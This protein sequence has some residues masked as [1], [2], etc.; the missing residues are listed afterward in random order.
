MK[1]LYLLGLNSE[2][3]EYSVVHSSSIANYSLRKSNYWLDKLLLIIILVSTASLSAQT[4]FK[5][6]LQNN[7]TET[8][9]WCNLQSPTILTL[10]SDEYGSVY[11]QVYKEGL[12]DVEGAADGIEAW[13]GISAVGSNPNPN[14]WAIWFPATYHGDSGNNDEYL[15]SIFTSYVGTYYMASRFRLNGGDFIYGGV[16]GTWNGIT[17]PSAALVITPNIMQCATNVSP[18]NG[19]LNVPVGYVNLSWNAPTSGPTPA[20]YDIYRVAEGQSY[21]LGTSTTTSFTM[22]VLTYYSLI[23]W[24]VV[25]R[26]ISGVPASSCTVN[27]FGTGANPLNPYCSNVVYSAGVHPITEVNFA[28]IDNSSTNEIVA[29]PS[30]QNFKDQYGFVSVGET[31]MLSIRGNTNGANVS[32]LKVFIDWNMDNDFNDDGESYD[33]GSIFNSDGINGEAAISYITVP[34]NALTGTTRMRIKKV[35]GTSTLSNP[36]TGGEYGQTEDYTLYVQGCETSIWYRDADGDGFGTVHSTLFSCSQPTGYVADN[37]DC[38]DNNANVNPNALEVLYNGI[39][40]NCDGSM[41]EGFM[42][43]TYIKPEFCGTILPQLDSKIFVRTLP[44]ASAYRFEVIAQSNGLVQYVETSNSYFRVTDMPFYAYGETYRISVQVRRFYTP[45]STN[46][47]LGYYGPPCLVSTPTPPISLMSNIR[48][49]GTTISVYGAL[50]AR[51]IP[52][53]TAYRFILKSHLDDPVGM[54]VTRDVPYVNLNM[55]SSYDYGTTYY[56]G[57][58]VKTMGIF[59]PYS[60]LCPVTTIS[61]Q[62]FGFGIAQCGKTYTNIYSSINAGSIPLATEYRFL[63]TRVFDGSQQIIDTYNTWIN[64][65]QFSFYSPSSEYSIAIAVRTS[66]EFST[67]GNPCSIYSPPASIA[68]GTTIVSADFKVV[69]SPN[70]FSDTF[71]LDITE[72]S[73]GNAEVR[74]FDMIG[75]LLE[76]RSVQSSDLSSQRLGN[77][78]PSG[79]YTVV[80][81]Q[82]D[83]VRT[84]K[85]IKR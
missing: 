82:G 63:I 11:A 32:N 54:V 9:D 80:V 31:Y 21:L 43:L 57:V 49:C 26:S 22:T 10:P 77:S 15:A 55:F 28:G 44:E 27:S 33:A 58:S 85:V 76:V 12:T 73:A 74:V 59:G 3:C 25:P 1:I 65:S 38:N 17:S 2:T 81:T 69:A 45:T 29:L 61:P 30:I 6:D 24:K 78:F 83:A 35:S 62:E 14:A 84:L 50:N 39:D 67:F 42:I 46:I 16:N 75:K 66:G 56:V 68:S 5:S 18:A 19:Q 53:A 4:S 60:K 72:G 47:W 40:D 79:V 70:P 51:I 8:L 36:C 41:D 37:T 23:Q 71:A 7:P 48:Q 20:T 52:G 34:Q 64:M 13:I